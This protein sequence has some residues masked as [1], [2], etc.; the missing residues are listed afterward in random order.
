MANDKRSSVD[1]FFDMFDDAIDNVDKFLPDP[2][3]GREHEE[4]TEKPR[5]RAVESRDIVVSRPRFILA[6][7]QAPWHIVRVSDNLVIASCMDRHEAVEICNL[8]N[9]YHR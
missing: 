4:S 7:G 2:D 3:A 5:S 1:T 9:R 6:G 8:M